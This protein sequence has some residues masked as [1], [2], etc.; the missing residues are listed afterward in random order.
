MG[1]KVGLTWNSVV[2]NSKGTSVH[3]WRIN[4][5]VWQNQHDIVK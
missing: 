1:S 5:D 3:P 4:V 2:I